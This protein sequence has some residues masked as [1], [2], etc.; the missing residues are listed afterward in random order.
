MQGQDGEHML[1]V[2][3]EK[4]HVSISDMKEKNSSCDEWCWHN[5]VSSDFITFPTLFIIDH[6]S[7][8]IN[9][10][11]ILLYIMEM[12]NNLKSPIYWRAFGAKWLLWNSPNYLM[13]CDL[14]YN[15]VFILSSECQKEKFTIDFL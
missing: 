15:I 7:T 5:S 2:S 11:S 13:L 1:S 3:W 4:E 10:L 8:F 12:S 6:T 14:F 9:D